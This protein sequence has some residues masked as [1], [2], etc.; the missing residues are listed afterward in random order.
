[1]GADRIAYGVRLSFRSSEN[2]LRDA[3]VD[4]VVARIVAKLDA[5]L[6]VVLRT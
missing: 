6:G 4:A 5:E 3:E 2:T 1:V